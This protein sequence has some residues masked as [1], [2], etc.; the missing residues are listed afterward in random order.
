MKRKKNRYKLLYFLLYLLKYKRKYLLYLN[1]IKKRILDKKRKYIKIKV[2]IAYLYGGG[3][4]LDLKKYGNKYYYKNKLLR[5]DDPGNIHFGYIGYM[6]FPKNGWYCKRKYIKW[7]YSRSWSLSDEQCKYFYNRW[8]SS[9]LVIISSKSDLK[10]ILTHKNFKGIK[11]GDIAYISHTKS[12]SGIHHST[13]ITV[14]NKKK[15]CYTAHNKPRKD[16][17]ITT[18]IKSLGEKGSIFILKL[19]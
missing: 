13:M 2:Y 7:R 16:E 11:A 1:S 18:A 8:R 9:R 19:K 6:F 12:T 5:E 15:M 3:F 14:I 17:N 4:V 10:K